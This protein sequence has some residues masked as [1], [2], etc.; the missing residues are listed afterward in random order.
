[1]SV[2][3]I[4]F[5]VNYSKTFG[6]RNKRFSLVYFNR[7]KSERERYRILNG[8]VCESEIAQSWLH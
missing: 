1:M 6:V 8:N 7:K 3:A 4:D 5:E 2:L